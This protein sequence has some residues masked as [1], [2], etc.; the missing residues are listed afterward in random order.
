MS[1]STQS[2]SADGIRILATNRRAARDYHILDRVEAGVQLLGSEIKSLREGKLS[3]DQAFARVEG[4]EVFLYNMNI[5]P[6][7]HSGSYSHDPLRPRK[8][9]LH[10]SQIRRLWGQTSAR[11]YTL[12]PL[13][14]YLRRGWAK[15]ELGLCR[16]K[17]Q[18]DRREDLKRRAE[19]RE[20]RRRLGR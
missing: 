20:M 18:R 6:Y 12:I 9:L 10:K 14:V 13:K 8:L 17:I 2:P 5:P 16:G 4:E 7:S 15:V 3:I 11:G 19:E 1:G